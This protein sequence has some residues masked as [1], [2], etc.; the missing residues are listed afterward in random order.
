M[1]LTIEAHAA[2]KT[3][4]IPNNGE[5]VNCLPGPV[6]VSASV[7]QSLTA[8]M[9]SHRSREYLQLHHET[10]NRLKQ[11]VGAKHVQI[12]TGSGTLA[13]EVVAGQLSLLP[14]KG[15]ILSNGE[16]GERLARQAGCFGLMFD[17]L[18][19]PWGQACDERQIR[20]T[21]SQQ[22]DLRWLWTVY[23]ESSTGMLNDL[24][25]L[26]A[27]ANEYGLHLCLDCISAVG[28]T[29][30]DLQNVYL[31]S[32]CS[33]KGLRS[34]AGLA[35]VFYNHTLTPPMRPLPMYLDLYAYEKANGVPFTIP[36]NLVGALATALKECDVRQRCLN[37]KTLDTWLRCRLARLGLIPLVTASQAC[38]GVITLPLPKPLCSREV[39]DRLKDVGFLTSYE[40][41]YLI[42]RN[43]LQI[44][45][46]SDVSKQQLRTL[47]N[48]LEQVIGNRLQTAQSKSC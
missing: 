41:C 9:L 45:L 26:T 42:E 21:I 44:C 11:L 6:A 1:Y 25:M 27:V 35:L 22:P 3:S 32:A 2:S 29:P 19:L 46:M 24:D 20:R 8:P 17:T 34:V 33:S 5:P 7:R 15:L 10:Q 31:A 48:A 30:V 16:F 12:F 38:P 18:S 43:W 28:N 40:S 36:S 47:V 37:I 14:G 23:S 13:N 39:G 4:F